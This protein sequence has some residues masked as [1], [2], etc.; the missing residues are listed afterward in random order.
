MIHS[1]LIKKVWW[2]CNGTEEGML[3]RGRQEGQ[4]GFSGTYRLLPSSLVRKEEGS[5]VRA[6][7]IHTLRE[8]RS[9]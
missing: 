8:P 4:L 2:L 6:T 9:G 1:P 7:C 3:P 5:M